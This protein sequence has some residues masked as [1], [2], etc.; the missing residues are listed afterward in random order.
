MRYAIIHDFSG[1][2]MSIIDIETMWQFSIADDNSM[3]QQ[4]LAWLAEGNTPEEWNPD[5]SV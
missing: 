5:G 1:N 3:Y 2:P 4:Y